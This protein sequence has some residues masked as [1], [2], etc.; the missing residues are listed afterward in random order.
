MTWRSRTKVDVSLKE[1][2]SAIKPGEHGC[3]I[4]FSKEE[5]Q[6]IQFEFV[7]SG[8]EDNWGVVHVTATESPDEIRNSM[9]K[10]GIDTQRYEKQNDGAYSSSSSSSSNS[11]ILIKGVEMY[12]NPADPDIKN[13][14][15]TLKSILDA[16][17]SNGKRGVRVASDIASYFIVNG[18]I[19]QWNKL[20]DVFKTFSSSPMSF[21][22]SYDSGSPKVWDVDILKPYSN[23]NNSVFKDFTEPHG[24]VIFT[25]GQQALIYTI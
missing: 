17:I 20:N 8:L 13:W 2:L 16:F 6:N 25:S 21:L 23:I 4:S 7:K 11:L 10:Y 19:E 9:Q 3:S 1:F 14:A 12:K 18:F 22:C 15:N 5:S 24:F